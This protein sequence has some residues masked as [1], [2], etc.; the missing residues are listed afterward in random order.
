MTI[1]FGQTT[2]DNLVKLRPG[3]RGFLLHGDVT[4]SQRAGFELSNA[5]PQAYK[6][7]ILQAIELGFLKPVATVREHELTWEMLNK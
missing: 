7:V 1:E 4:I 6:D 5:C 2:N 3:D